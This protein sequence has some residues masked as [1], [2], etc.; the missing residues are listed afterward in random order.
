MTCNAFPTV[1]AQPMRAFAWD[2]RKERTCSFFSFA[3]GLVT[4]WAFSRLPVKKCFVGI[5]VLGNPLARDR[6][7]AFIRTVECKV[8]AFPSEKA[9]FEGDKLSPSKN[10]TLRPKGTNAPHSP[11]FH[12]ILTWRRLERSSRAD[13]CRLG[14]FQRRCRA[15]KPAV[16]GSVQSSFALWRFK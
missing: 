4:D 7:H 6:R 11:F 15:Q 5:Q 10:Q 8:R 1:F 13:A 16:L 2:V 3:K 14:L 9:I 12:L